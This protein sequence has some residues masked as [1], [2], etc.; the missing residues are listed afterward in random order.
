M[1]TYQNT[2][3]DSDRLIIGNYKLETAPTAGGTFV[4]MGAGMV[5][6]FSHDFEKWDVQAGNAPDPIEG[7]AT[8]TVAIGFDLIEYDASV[9]NAFQGGLISAPTI[10]SVLSTVEA[11]GNTELTPQAFKLTNIR[12]NGS[13]STVETT[14]TVYRAT[15]DSGMTLVTKSDNDTDPINAMQFTITGELDTAR[16][17]GNQLY[18]ID[19]TETP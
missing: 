19:H 15:I 1:A 13:G 17:A 9:L 6:A 4:N 8:E 3:V 18:T 5:T 10:T 16:T 12:V 7:I 2:S 14:I 11:G